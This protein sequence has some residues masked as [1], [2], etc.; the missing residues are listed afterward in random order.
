MNTPAGD[1]GILDPAQLRRIESVHRGFLYQ[2][3]FAVG[4]LLVLGK[5]G[6]D[7]L[8]VERDEDVE[9]TFSSKKL[10]I[11]VKTRGAPLQI[12][13]IHDALERFDAIR[14]LH[15][16]GNRPKPSE[17]WIVSNSDPSPSSIERVTSPNWPSDVFLQTPGYSS[18]YRGVLPPSWKDLREAF[19][20]CQRCADAVPFRALSAE[21]LVWKLAAL[22]QFASSGTAPRT[23]HQF[24][25]SELSQLFEQLVIQLHQLPI[26]PLFYRAQENEPPF[27]SSQKVR[28][29]LGHSGAG[30]TTWAAHGAIHSGHTVVYFDVGDTPGPALASSLARELAAR[31]VSDDPDGFRKVFFP[32]A[33]ALDSLRAL[34]LQF[35]RRQ[36]AP[37]VVIDNTQKVPSEDVCAVI[38]AVTSAQWILLAQPW[39]ERVAIEAS[40]QTRA[41]VL[42]GWS[43]TTVC[44]ELARTGCAATVPTCERVRRL[45]GGLPLYVQ[46]VALLAREVYGGDTERL[47]EDIESSMT[48]ATTAQHTIVKRVLE[49]LSSA[50]RQA[51]SILAL[52]DVPLAKEEALLLLSKALAM[53]G[54]ASAA[55]VKEL[56]GWGILELRLDGLLVSHEAFRLAVSEGLGSLDAQRLETALKTLA[57]LLFKSLE[58]RNLDRFRLYCKLLPK[59]GEVKALVEVVGSLSEYFAEYGFAEEFN[60]ILSS[61]VESSSTP[62]GDRFWAVD[63]LL[64]WELQ[65]NSDRKTCAGRIELMEILLPEV[66]GDPT[67]AFALELKRMIFFGLDG[68]QDAA[69][70]SYLELCKAQVGSAEQLRVIRYDYALALFHCDELP[71]AETITKELVAEYFDVLGLGPEDVVLQN[72][73]DIQKKVSKSADLPD[74]LKRVADTLELHALVLQRR[75]L[76]TSLVRFQAF[77]FFVM[78]GAITS[79]IRI[80]QDFVED[81]LREQGDAETAREFMEKHLLPHLNETK[82][83]GHLVSVQAQYAVVLAYCGEVEAARK[84]MAS[85]EPYVKAWPQGS[86]EFRN[87]DCLIEEIARGKVQLRPSMSFKRSHTLA[88]SASKIGRN[89]KC[90]CGS[91]L[92][93]K[94][95]CGR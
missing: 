48:L 69:R 34:N 42:S 31:L 16:G 66:R 71:E 50:A 59:I 25:A 43:M 30:K 65:R 24:E 60:Q 64:F 81:C 38:Q 67:A 91:G 84:L 21:T 68:N 57:A 92:K 8:L 86:M 72:I 55:L 76:P 52:S 93:Y 23:A 47:C 2:H 58:T 1:L 51:I 7:S 41:E 35:V 53:E 88:V 9:I 29:I 37:I 45:T 5:I 27:S 83:F 63:S 70:S 85:L 15:E 74:D 44:D 13:H 79:V 82:L 11:Q 78:G 75:G 46:N 10:Y 80:G 90:P 36:I 94:Q 39:P 20:W 32:G 3:L 95:C 19:E 89:E 22:I 62:A 17:F 40:L 26:P 73:R 4:C 14:K 77:K 28:L 87:Q 56:L 6:A 54:T 49:R 33:T 18:G 61:V 12:S